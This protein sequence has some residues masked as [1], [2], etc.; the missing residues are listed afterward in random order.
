[1]LAPRGSSHRVTDVSLGGATRLGRPS[2]SWQKV[3]PGGSLD[4]CG[5]GYPVDFWA[6]TDIL[7]WIQLSSPFGDTGSVAP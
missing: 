7:Q 4:S 6:R 3:L 5:A 1:M 2:A